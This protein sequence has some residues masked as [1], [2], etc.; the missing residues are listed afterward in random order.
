MSVTAQYNQYKCTSIQCNFSSAAVDN[1]IDHIKI[2]HTVEPVFNF[3]CVNRLPSRCRR[4]FLSFVGLQKHLKTE[5]PEKSNLTLNKIIKCDL[6]ES[7]PTTVKE[8]KCHYINHWNFDKAP[9]KCIFKECNYKTTLNETSLTKIKS[10]WK[11]HA[12]KNHPLDGYQ[13]EGNLEEN[14]LFDF[15]FLYLMLLHIF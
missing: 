13:T 1:I 12:S 5:H 4:K 11:I 8:L 14:L 15:T 3:E 10:N 6:C 7:S 2:T 9:L